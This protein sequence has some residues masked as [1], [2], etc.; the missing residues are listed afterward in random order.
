MQSIAEKFGPA[1]RSKRLNEYYQAAQ[2]DQSNGRLP[3]SNV[4][5]ADTNNLHYIVDGQNSRHPALNLLF[6]T[7]PE[8][9]VWQVQ[10]LQR[11]AYKDPVRARFIV[12][13]THREQHCDTI[14]VKIENGK[15]S[16][17]GI[18]AVSL[19]KYNSALDIAIAFTEHCKEAMPELKLIFLQS[20]AQK[21]NVGCKIFAQ[22]NAKAMLTEQ[23]HMDQL[24]QKNLAANITTNKDHCVNLPNSHRLLPAS[25]MKYSQSKTV[26]NTYL[27]S[28][29]A[30]KQWKD[31]HGRSLLNRIEQYR[32]TRKNF[33]PGSHEKLFVTY[34]DKIEHKRLKLIQ[35]TL[36]QSI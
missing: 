22:T 17:I 27:K 13:A 20:Q 30:A 1:D 31:H 9:F 2:R 26:V 36:R 35:N 14:D 18:T 16:A 12:K 7:G 23:T 4:G 33:E 6:A 10:K 21:S 25:F 32:V 24:H 15:V 34:S 11:G 29:P 5:Y 28:N 3:T 8:D 19:D